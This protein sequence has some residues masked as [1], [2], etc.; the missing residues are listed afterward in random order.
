MT[1]P[2]GERDM[3]M[4]TALMRAVELRATDIHIVVGRPVMCRIQG[5]LV[6]IGENNL[7][8]ADARTL[9]YS[10]LSSAQVRE[11]EHELDLDFVKPLGRNR[12]R[13]NLSHNNGT[14]SAVIR[15]LNVEPLRLEAI[16]LPP[17]VEEI[18][19][20]DKGL[21]LVTGTTSQGKT[22]TMAA[23]VDY[24]NR[25]RNRNV[26]TIE[27][28]IEYLHEN[29]QSIVRQREV[30][31]DTRSFATGLKAALRQ[32]PNVIV[33]GEMRDYESIQIALTA[34]ETGALVMSTL[35]TLS[36]DKVLERLLSYV[37]SDQET[38]IRLMLAESLLCIIHQELL[39]TLAGG[40]RVACEVLMNSNAVRNTIRKRETYHLK[41][42]ILT[43][44]KTHGMRS[45]KHSL[46]QL[47]AEE[48]ISP[49]TYEQVLVNYA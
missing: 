42:F 15:V 4:M 19:Y 12:F 29:K 23:L 22:T 8:A 40:K 46:D 37:P 41:S 1:G 10:L 17:I 34:A 33:I 25:H 28:P 9:C 21:V 16:R 48:E 30:G 47:L 27:D 31:K 18:C 26:I 6:A 36:I 39:S 5:E 3:S 44:E 13:I 38:Q 20:R 49:E 24:I 7:S 43:S 32:D 35:H 11:F 14:V 45:M 2:A